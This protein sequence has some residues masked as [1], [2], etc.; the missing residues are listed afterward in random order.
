[1]TTLHQPTLRVIK[2]IEILKNNSDGLTISQIAKNCEISVGTLHPILKTLYKLN[3]LNYENKVY[4]LSFLFSSEMEQEKAIK[5]IK[6]YMEKLAQKI[7]L[8]VQLGVLSGKNV[9]YLHKCVGGK[10]ALITKA[11]DIS[12]ANMSSL[13][14]ALLS[15][16]T[17]DELK[18]IFESD[19][20]NQKTSKTIDNIDD[21]YENILKCKSLGYFF[22]NGEFDENFACFAVPIVKNDKIF[23]AISVT[24]LIFL[25]NEKEQ[26]KIINNLLEYKK[27]IEKEL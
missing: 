5:V 23:A 12:D 4:K 20:L 24:T 19:T 18:K 2:I 1:M 14:K 27:M 21:L 26:N 7:E 13:G 16:K 17:K 15:D 8:G 25:L 9:I 6:F 3:Y 11:G 10:I 22:E